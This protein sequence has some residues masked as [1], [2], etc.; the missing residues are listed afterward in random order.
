M[1]GKLTVGAG[2][3]GEGHS[4][5][6]T[7]APKVS[8]K[9]A[10]RNIDDVLDAGALTLQAKLDEAAT[11]TAVATA[12]E[13]QVAK[14]RAK[15]DPGRGR[16]TANLTSAG[17]RLLRKSKKITLTVAVTAQDAAGNAG[18]TTVAAKLR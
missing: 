8:V 3:S 2:G 9:A 10:D 7:K 11:V 4:G 17:K 13:A 5:H 14:G 18:K 16:L 12:G 6:D 15:L 1:T